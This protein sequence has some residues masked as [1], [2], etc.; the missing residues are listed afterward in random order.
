[1]VGDPDIRAVEGYSVSVCADGE[2]ARAHVRRINN[3]CARAVAGSQF[4]DVVAAKVGHPDVRAVG[5]H[6]KRSISGSESAK[7]SAVAGPDFR[8]TP[9]AVVRH[10]DIG[11]VK[12]YS[13]W[14]CSDCYCDAGLVRLIPMQRGD[15]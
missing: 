10:P 4:G 14:V 7:H 12:S 2:G 8:D 3:P 5:G 1:M 13:Q 9:A 11:A 15:L 6:A